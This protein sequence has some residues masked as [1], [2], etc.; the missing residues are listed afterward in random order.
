MDAP[1]PHLRIVSPPLD[2]VAPHRLA[3]CMDDRPDLY[4]SFA[5]TPRPSRVHPL[6][7]VLGLSLLL[8]AV[9]LTW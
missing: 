6:A 1:R 9:V 5:S 8:G 2:Y 3:Q 7:W 4:A